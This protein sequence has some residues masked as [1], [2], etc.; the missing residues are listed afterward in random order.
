MLPAN[1]LIDK[2]KEMCEGKS[3]ASL[4]RRLEVTPQTISQWKSGDVPLPT[5]RIVELAKVAHVPVDEWVLRI[6]SDQ[7]KGEARRVLEGVMKKIGYAAAV[8]LCVI[9][10]SGAM[11]GKA[12]AVSV[13]SPETP[14]V[15]QSMPIM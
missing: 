1:K 4:A 8:A 3:Y 12:Y 14:G 11:P 6:L 15:F 2:A 7:S 5:E 13:S 9:G 10:F